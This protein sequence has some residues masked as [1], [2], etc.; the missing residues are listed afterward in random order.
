MHNAKFLTFRRCSAEGLTCESVG[1]AEP[2]DDWIKGQRVNQVNQQM[3]QALHNHH[4]QT[5]L[6]RNSLIR[7]SWRNRKC[8]TCKFMSWCAIWRCFVLSQSLSK[9]A[10]MSTSAGDPDAVWGSL[11]ILAQGCNWN[12]APRA[13]EA[14][15]CK[16]TRAVPLSTAHPG[17]ENSGFHF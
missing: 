14:V 4:Q 6:Q 16:D 7:R 1:S 8:N 5:E 15:T 10:L 2:K 13:A 17:R 11:T 3:Y 12:E 9:W